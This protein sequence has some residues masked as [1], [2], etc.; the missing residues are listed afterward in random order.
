ME[1]TKRLASL[2]V[3]PE[4]PPRDTEP[5]A[6][7]LIDVFK[8]FRAGLDRDRGAPG[9]ELEGRARG[10]WSP[11]SAPQ[12]AARARCSR[13]AAAMDVPSA[14]DVRVDGRSLAR[15]DENELA[16]IRGREIAVVFQS[17]NLWPTLSARENVAAA[18]SLAS[19][20]PRPAR[21]CRRGTGDI[22]P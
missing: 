10:R 18:V 9:P 1:A 2:Y 11:S 22:R 3:E 15:L 16:R 13:S 4:Q 12:G 6:L 8:I 7:E 17:D 20:G 21:G 5:P 14:G 19:L